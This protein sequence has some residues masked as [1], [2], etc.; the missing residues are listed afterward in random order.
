MSNQQHGKEN[1]FNVEKIHDV[2]KD[3]DRKLYLVEWEGFPDEKDYTWEPHTNLKDCVIFK[4][5]LS[6]K[7]WKKRKRESRDIVVKDVFKKT[8]RYSLT[9]DERF[10]VIQRQNYK[11]NLCLNP[12]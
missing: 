5:F 3:K 7:K 9:K 10:D 6:S 8:N 2:K 4:N 11:C 12:F 1:N